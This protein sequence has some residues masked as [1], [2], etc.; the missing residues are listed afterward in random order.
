MNRPLPRPPWLSQLLIRVTAPSDD[1]RA[2]LGDLDE[3]FAV[4][5]RTVSVAAARMWYRRQVMASVVPNVTLRIR[6]RRRRMTR[7]RG[8]GI[9]QTVFQD[10]RYAFRSFRRQWA[11]SF[12][13]VGTLAL[14]IG[15]NTVVYSVVDGVI[16]NPFPFPEPDRLVGVGTEWPRL[17]RELEF[18]E[19]LSPPEYVDVKAQSQTLEH[20]VMWDM[21]YRAASVGTEPPEVLFSG[22]WFDDAFPTLDMPPVIGRGF[23]RE[24][25]ERGD[26]VAIISHRHWQSRLGGDPNVIGRAMYV[27]GEPYTLIGVMPPRGLIYAMDLWIPIGASPDRWSRNRR[28]M[29]ILARIAPGYSL[30]EVN[31][32]L[33]AIAGRIEQE[34]ASQYE[35]YRGWRMQALEWTDANVRM[36]KPAAFA[37][38]GAV[39]FV[40][41]IVCTNIANLLLARSSSRR[42]EVAVRCALGAGRSRIIRQLLTESVLLA[43]IG[44]AIGVVLTY[45][46]VPVILASIPISLPIALDVNVNP[47]V[48]AFTA[49]VS[50]AAGL[51]FGLVPAWQ[52]ARSDLQSALKVETGGTT[53]GQRHGLQRV[54]VGAEFAV[55]LALLVQAGL[56]VN[57][58]VRLQ[59][60]DP[61][62]DTSNTLTMRLTLPFSRYPNTEARRTFFMQ[63][64]ERIEQLRGVRLAGAGNQYP[65]EVFS[66]NRFGVEGEAYESEEAL[67]TAF[68]TLVTDGYHEVLGIPLLRGRT[69]T[70]QDTPNTPYV[71]VINEVAERRY[72]PD[73]NAIGRRFKTGGTDSDGPWVTIVGVVG[74]VHNRGVDTPPQPE[75]FGNSRQFPGGNQMYVVVRT[76]RDPRAVLPAVQQTV[77]AMDPDQSVYAVRTLDDAFQEQIAPRRTGTLAL[78][79][80][81]LFALGLAGAG[82]YSVVSFGV[83]E[84]KREIGL[85]IALG[86]S[87]NAVRRLVVRQAMIPVAIGGAVGLIGALLMSRAMAGFL[88]EVNGADPL[89]IGIVA[90]V[91]AAFAVVASYLPAR[92]AS[93]LDPV[94][95]L[96]DQG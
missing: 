41:L 66:R 89:T 2:I 11:F 40:L 6:K 86:A 67:P 16:L 12:V 36:I 8:D 31:T 18:W 57:S 45:V 84:R 79:G 69:F 59:N 52:A 70:D 63:L 53:G 83:G 74:A 46:A 38:M 37:L 3:E 60:V 82:I 77:A 92:R 23:T 95:A 91:L 56:M 1:R 25:L 24:E 55:A 10:V 35:E 26:R 17:S 28:Q 76:E 93:G 34:Y 14:G 19:V 39:A 27:E 13:I 49:A 94:V 5:A 58:F 75:F 96:R 90:A 9:M 85:R 71:A 22:F 78:A 30:E 80:F 47:R 44:G 73:G 21:G 61:G 62:F 15:A 81:A 68:F 20:V 7:R 43:L 32:E 87:S 50:I 33:A 54:F 29:Q 48:L 72:F 65:P 42:R 51:V 4:R 64:V 88:F